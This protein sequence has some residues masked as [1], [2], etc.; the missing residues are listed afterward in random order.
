L[1][2]R[3][4]IGQIPWAVEQGNESTEQGAQLAEQ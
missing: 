4:T 3:Q 2:F 1:L